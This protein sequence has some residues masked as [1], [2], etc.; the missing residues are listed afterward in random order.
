[1]AMNDY[2]VATT[3]VSQLGVTQLDNSGKT[4]WNPGVNMLLNIRINTWR[5]VNMSP[6][7]STIPHPVSRGCYLHSSSSVV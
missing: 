7:F 6:H 2:I 3:W 4:L 5:P 1:M